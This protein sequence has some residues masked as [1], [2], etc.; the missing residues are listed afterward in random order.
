MD[1]RDS[2]DETKDMNITL[3]QVSKH[4]SIWVPLRTLVEEKVSSIMKDNFTLKRTAYPE[5]SP[6][7]QVSH[8]GVTGVIP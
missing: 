4:F 7:E 1:L 2:G 5:F 6:A 3:I 8:C